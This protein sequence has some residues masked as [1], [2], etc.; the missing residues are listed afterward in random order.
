VRIQTAERGRVAR[1]QFAELKRRNAAAIRLQAWARG[2]QQ[3][4]RYLRVL[5]AVLVLQI[6]VR[7]WQLSKRMAIREA[8]RRA[9]EA[10][11]AKLAAA[12][13]AKHAAEEASAKEARRK[14]R[15]SFAAIKA[16]LLS[17]S[18]RSHCT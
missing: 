18:P 1:R 15:A 13:A 12:E 7:R 9:R 5:R 14:E 8:E 3:R 17:A 11:Q 4:V 16:R 10:E 2:H 6:A